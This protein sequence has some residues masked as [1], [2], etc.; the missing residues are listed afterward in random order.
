[1]AS[2]VG[3]PHIDGAMRNNP[4]IGLTVTLF[5][6]ASSFP[7]IKSGLDGFSPLELAAFFGQTETVRLLL[8][9][10]ADRTK[11]AGLAAMKG[12]LDVLELLKGRQV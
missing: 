8:A 12:H 4:Y 5:L 9:R 6:W 2:W 11:A 10:G 7:A 3:G 1:M